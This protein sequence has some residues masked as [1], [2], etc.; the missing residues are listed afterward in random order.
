VVHPSLPCRAVTCRCAVCFPFHSG[1]FSGG[2]NGFIIR[3]I[4]QIRHWILILI[5]YA[6]SLFDRLLL[7]GF[8]T[9]NILVLWR[10]VVVY[11]KVVQYSRE[12][13]ATDRIWLEFF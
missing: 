10:T 11:L 1:L 3:K 8:G 5:S 9:P 6:C 4:K 2:P 13:L 12:R 7:S